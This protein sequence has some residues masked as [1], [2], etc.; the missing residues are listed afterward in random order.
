MASR[1][2]LPMPAANT[3]NRNGPFWDFERDWCRAEKAE[4]AWT[5]DCHNSAPIQNRQSLP[6]AAANDTPGAH[7][8]PGDAGN[9]VGLSLGR[10]DRMRVPDFNGQNEPTRGSATHHQVWD[11]PAASHLQGLLG[12]NSDRQPFSK[13]WLQRSPFHPAMESPDGHFPRQKLLL[14]QVDRLAVNAD[15]L[16]RTH[17]LPRVVPPS[18][19]ALGSE[20]A[21]FLLAHVALLE[22]VSVRVS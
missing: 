15:R 22:L 11:V 20:S 4:L 6:K 12:P 19:I 21:L 3:E 2:K 9:L 14:N 5:L 17:S 1:R 18:R 8:D 10:R 16:A 13:Q 7:L